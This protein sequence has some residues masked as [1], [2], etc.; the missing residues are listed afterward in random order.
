MR[1]YFVRPGAVPPISVRAVRYVTTRHVQIS[2]RK[3]VPLISEGYHWSDTFIEARDWLA[4]YY[5]ARADQAETLASA[6]RDKAVV[7]DQLT[8][9][10]LGYPILI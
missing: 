9:D 3:Q 2:D 1:L 7:A 8:V 5:R 4:S 6:L 10:D